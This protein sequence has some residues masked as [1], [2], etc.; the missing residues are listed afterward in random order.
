MQS[1]RSL[2]R[3]FLGATTTI[4][5]TGWL[6]LAPSPALAQGCSD[7]DGDGVCDVDDNCVNTFNPAQSD[8]DADGVGDVCDNCPFDANPAQRD[9]DGDGIGD[10]CETDSDND[11]ILDDGDASGSIIGGWR[12]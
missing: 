11:G 12:G 7:L 6:A 2:F 9:T 5:V 8:A 3:T 4:L 10:V 1:A